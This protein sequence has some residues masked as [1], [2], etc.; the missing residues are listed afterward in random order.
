M[1]VHGNSETLQ[2]VLELVVEQRRSTCPRGSFTKFAVFIIFIVMDNDVQS[3]TRIVIVV[4][5]FIWSNPTNEDIQIENPTMG[6]SHLLVDSLSSVTTLI[7]SD[8]TW[9][10]ELNIWVKYHA[11]GLFMSAMTWVL[12]TQNDSY[13]IWRSDKLGKKMKQTKISKIK[14]LVDSGVWKSY[15]IGWKEG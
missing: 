7:W 3:S 12:Q 14:K 11:E 4:L 9:F 10:G 6:R 8:V 5:N 1:K 15:F 13:L 2:K